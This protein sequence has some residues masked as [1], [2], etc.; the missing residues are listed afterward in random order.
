MAAARRERD[1]LESVLDELSRAETEQDFADIRR[2]LREAGHIRGG[3]SGKRE[4]RRGP[5]RPRAQRITWEPWM[6]WVWNQ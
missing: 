6:R 1:W 4:P 2:E 5:S 3:V